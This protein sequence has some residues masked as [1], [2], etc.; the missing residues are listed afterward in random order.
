MG[1][2]KCPLF[3]LHSPR[4]TVMLKPLQEEN[5]LHADFDESGL[6]KWQ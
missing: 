2:P 1:H 4:V 5:A 3:E 6:T